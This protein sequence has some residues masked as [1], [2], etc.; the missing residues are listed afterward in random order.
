[1]TWISVPRGTKFWFKGLCG[2]PTTLF[3]WG[4][5][6]KAWHV[7]TKTVLHPCFLVL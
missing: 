4:R 7:L 1:M 5:T 3:L 6:E 2:I